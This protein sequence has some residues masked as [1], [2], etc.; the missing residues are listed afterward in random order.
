MET[1]PQWHVQL[2]DGRK[3][4]PADMNTIVQWASQGRVP[5]EALLV[6]L[7]GEQTRSVLSQPEIKRILRAPPTMPSPIAA[8]ASTST[9]LIPTAN[10]KALSG[11]YCAVAGL[12]PFIGLPLAIAAIVLGIYGIRAWSAD[13]AVKGIA[14]AWVA[15]ILG[16]IDVAISVFLGFVIIWSM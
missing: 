14:H 16:L 9:G 1:S 12:I 10:P 2:S 7:D 3:F 13:H 5:E 15:I 6:S 11:Y 8:R 4:G